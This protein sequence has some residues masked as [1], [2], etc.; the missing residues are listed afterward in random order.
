MFIFNDFDTNCI[1]KNIYTNKFE[2]RIIELHLLR[3]KIISIHF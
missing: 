3:K 1:K 2:I